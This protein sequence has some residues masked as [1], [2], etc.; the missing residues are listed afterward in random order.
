MKVGIYK[1]PIANYQREYSNLMK[2]KR[3]L[4][5]KLGDNYKIQLKDALPVP[6]SVRNAKEAKEGL[7]R[8][9]ALRAEVN[10]ALI[11]E[12]VGVKRDTGAVIETSSLF[13]VLDAM[14]AV[15]FKEL[16]DRVSVIVEAKRMGLPEPVFEDLEPITVYTGSQAS[17]EKKIKGLR[18]K[19]SGRWWHGGKYVAP[20]DVMIEN[21]KA[22]LSAMPAEVEDL[23]LLALA[24]LQPKTIAARFDAIYNTSEKVKKEWVAFWDS[25][26]AY[27]VRFMDL[28][29]QGCGVKEQ[30]ATDFVAYLNAGDTVAMTDI[31]L[32]YS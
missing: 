25:R 14:E 2:A 30:D 29:L 28:F 9:R 6:S 1:S 23:G 22:V 4:E 27:Q 18:S 19:L 32:R 21:I 13:E 20:T 5:Q 11:K 26:S 24:R 12:S 8:I 3:R 31:I 17:T 16:Q 7:A 10:K 15:R